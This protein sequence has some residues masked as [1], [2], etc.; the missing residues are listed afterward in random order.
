MAAATTE[1]WKKKRKVLI[2]CFGSRGDVQPFAALARGLQDCQGGYQEV[3]GGEG[4]RFEVLGITNI[5]DG[6]SIFRSLGV[7]AVGVHFD[8]ANFI[9][10]DPKMKKA[11]E[12]GSAVQFGT[13]MT[14]QFIRHFPKEFSQQ[15]KVAKDFQPDLILATSLTW[16]QASAIG[17]ALRVPV[18][19]A[20]LG[21]FS[22][23]PI[24]KST[25]TEMHE[26]KCLHKISSFFMVAGMSM[27]LKTKNKEGDSLYRAMHRDLFSASSDLDSGGSTI[28]AAA[29]VIPDS[30]HLLGEDGA[31]QFV[32]EWM[33]P[34]APNL[35]AISDSVLPKSNFDDLPPKYAERSI[36]TGNWYVSKT[37]QEELART[38]DPNFSNSNKED[39]LQQII[40]DFIQ[41]QRKSR[42][43]NEKV[44]SSD[45]VYIGWGS[46]VA[47]SPEYMTRLAVQSLKLAGLSGIVLG[48][49]AK[50][51]IDLLS[52]D[53]DKDLYDYAKKHVLFLQSAPH[54]WLFPKC[55]VTLHH[56]GAGTTAAALRSGV[57]TIV[58]PCIADQYDNASLI[59][60]AGC[61]FGFKKPLRKTSAKE[62]ANALTKCAGSDA[63]NGDFYNSIRFNCKRVAGAL[64]K[65]DGTHNAIRVIEEFV[66]TKLDSGKWKEEFEARL[67]QRSKNP[68]SFWYALY[69]MMFYRNPFIED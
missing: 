46:M 50:L 29:A 19:H 16:I 56:G 58:T 41:R 15:W 40:L 27:V 31:G 66:I 2:C 36:W 52:K 32:R 25:Q 18:V 37:I 68:W 7:K 54:E 33:N 59:E 64:G 20:D 51:G 1:T 65:E 69:R 47:V 9:R 39:D 5:N 63:G 10:E 13:I 22:F 61:G 26:P 24:S 14:K 48:G 67:Q 8:I 21:P 53:D 23:L 43:G 42:S 11:L 62:L 12:T 28:A 38:G 49:F 44:L 17:H 6:E 45:P 35:F 30:E 57:P 3:L 4:L 60:E 55:C 34:L